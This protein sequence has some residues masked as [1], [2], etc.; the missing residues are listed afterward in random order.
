MLFVALLEVKGSS[1]PAERIARRAEWQ[2]PAGVKV[3]GE[4]WLQTDGYSVISI[5]ETDDNADIFAISSQWGDVFNVKVSP[6]LTA[7]Q[8]LQLAQKM[9]Q[10]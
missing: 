6:A 3:I 4:Y 9:M 1:A 10:G 2:Y 8:G 5:M 7:E